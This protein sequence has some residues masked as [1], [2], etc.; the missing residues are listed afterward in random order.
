LTGINNAGTIVGSADGDAALWENGAEVN[1]NSEVASQLPAG[2]TLAGALAINNSGQILATAFDSKTDSS[3]SYV[4]NPTSSP[5][6]APE[7]DSASAVGG[8]AIL[9]SSLAILRGRRR[10][11]LALLSEDRA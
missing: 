1:L 2:Y 9:F 10:P 8:L 4:L 3:L 7:I 5:L 6:G 11:T